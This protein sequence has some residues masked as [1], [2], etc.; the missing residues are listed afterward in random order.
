MYLTVTTLSATGLNNEISPSDHFR[1]FNVKKCHHYCSDLH[2]SFNNE[3]LVDMLLHL[4]NRLFKQLSYMFCNF[5]T[6][7]RL[8]NRNILK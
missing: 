5:E 3:Y 8:A 7:K 4:K 1:Y 6:T 2:Y